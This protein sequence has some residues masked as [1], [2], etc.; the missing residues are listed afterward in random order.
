MTKKLATVFKNNDIYLV[1]S[2]TIFSLFG[3]ILILLG[4][5]TKNINW[6]WGGVGII[7]IG[8]ILGLTLISLGLFTI[9][10]AVKERRLKKVN[11]N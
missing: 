4:G 5:I 11:K 6:V 7:V 3:I 8:I 1:G 2:F 9:I 10:D